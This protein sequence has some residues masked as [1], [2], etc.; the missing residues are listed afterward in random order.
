MRTD[1]PKGDIPVLI[2]TVLGETPRHGY[3]IA[4][5]IERLS[6]DALKLREGSLYPALRVLEQDGLIEGNWQ[7]PGSGPARKVYAITNAGRS[8]LAKRT[9]EWRQYARIMG[10]LLGSAGEESA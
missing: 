1:F 10:A 8:E 6:A 2:L 9:A 4:R 3:A 5:E 7:I